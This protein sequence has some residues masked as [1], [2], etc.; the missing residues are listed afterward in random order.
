MSNEFGFIIS[1]ND[2]DYNDPEF[3][4]AAREWDANWRVN[5]PNK[6]P[7]PTPPKLAEPLW[8]VSLPHQ[9]DEW[10]IAAGPN[11]MCIPH[12]EAVARLEQFIKEAQ[13]AL[14]KLRRKEATP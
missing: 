7:Y 9:C 6:V 11:G 13:E 3:K 2:N 1:R 8:S 14:D 12:A 10:D 4:A 5:I